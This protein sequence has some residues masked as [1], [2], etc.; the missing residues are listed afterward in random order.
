MIRFAHV[1]GDIT[2]RAEPAVISELVEALSA[3][4]ALG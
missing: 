2:E 1:S 3:A 4:P